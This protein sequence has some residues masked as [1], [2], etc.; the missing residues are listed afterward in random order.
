MAETSQSI[1][2]TIARQTGLLSEERAEL[3]VGLQKLDRIRGRQRSVEQLAVGERFMTPEQ[4]RKVL[5]AV[6]YYVIRRHD[7]RYARTARDLGFI[8]WHT[9]D[10]C[11]KLQKRW[12]MEHRLLVRLGKILLRRGEITPQQDAVVRRELTSAA[13]A[14]SDGSRSGRVPAH[15]ASGRAPAQAERRSSSRRTHAR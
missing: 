6:R 15:A 12:Y 13:R 11:L 1:F 9:F 2:L 3:L 4:V 8:S 10:R 14:R 7:R 5:K